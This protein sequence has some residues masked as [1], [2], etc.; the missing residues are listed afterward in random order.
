MTPVE[1]ARVLEQLRALV[2]AMRPLE[3]KLERMQ[4]ERRG[5]M[6]AARELGA[7]DAAI[8]EAVGVTR[9][10]VSQMLGPHNRKG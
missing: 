3:D 6:A 9:A 10:R 7:T 2:T 8:A 5:R 1:R 4:S